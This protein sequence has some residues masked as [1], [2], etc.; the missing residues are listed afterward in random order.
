MSDSGSGE[1]PGVTSPRGG[2]TLSA[3][4]NFFFPHVTA[5]VSGGDFLGFERFP[6]TTEEVFTVLL[7]W[8]IH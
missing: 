6:G 3:A 2:K 4:P 8:V 5:Y 7:W 1:K